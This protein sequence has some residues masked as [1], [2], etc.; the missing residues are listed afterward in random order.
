MEFKP[1]TQPGLVDRY[2]FTP[3]ARKIKNCADDG[4]HSGEWPSKTNG[5]K[6]L[7]DGN[8]GARK[9]TRSNS[10]VM[11]EDA[12]HTHNNL[13]AWGCHHPAVRLTFIFKRKGRSTW[14]SRLSFSFGMC[15][16]SPA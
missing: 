3:L 4:H 10:K 16:V 14:T 2:I 7:G 8:T 6:E 5:W 13:N 15:C 1:D 9:T 12:N 11:T